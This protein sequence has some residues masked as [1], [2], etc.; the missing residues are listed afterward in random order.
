[1]YK[2]L[3]KRAAAGRMR[4]EKPTRNTEHRKAPAE[5]S[6]ENNN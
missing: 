2:P 4:D 6:T 3:R 1:M 5:K